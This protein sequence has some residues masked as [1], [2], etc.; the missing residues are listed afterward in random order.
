M[1]DR[2]MAFVHCHS[3]QDARAIIEHWNK[4]PICGGDKPLQVRF[5]N[6]PGG[7]GPSGVTSGQDN[8]IL[9]P[10]FR[11]GKP[12]EPKPSENEGHDATGYSQLG[13]VS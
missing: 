2:L 9:P 4:K 11:K 6:A 5:K 8:C 7:G 3:L 10:E 12:I 1:P 13:T